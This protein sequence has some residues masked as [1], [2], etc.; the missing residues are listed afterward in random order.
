MKKIISVLILTGLA[1]CSSVQEV[2]VPPGSGTR[3]PELGVVLPDGRLS[4]DEGK[5]AQLRR[6]IRDRQLQ[7]DIMMDRLKRRTGRS[8]L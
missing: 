6:Q 1:A 3:F 5:Q 7:F 2:Q 8:G 4:K